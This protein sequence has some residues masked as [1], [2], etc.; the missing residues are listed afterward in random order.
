MSFFASDVMAV[1]I[2]NYSIKGVVLGAK[3]E[4]KKYASVPTPVGAIEGGI[5][6]EP[7]RVAGAVQAL[8]QTLGVK[9]PAVITAIPGQNVFVRLF[10]L[11]GLN[12]KELA[13]AVRYQA[14]GQIPIPPNELVVDWAVVQEIKATKQIEILVVATRK[15]VVQQFTFLFRQAGLQPRIFDLEALALSRIFFTKNH[16]VKP[17]ELELLASIGAAATNICVFEGDVPRFT[18][19]IP[20]GGQRF[21]R[22]LAMERS[23][24]L[25]EAEEFKLSGEMPAESASLL[26]DLAGE[27][28]RSIDFFLSQNKEQNIGR[29]ILSGGGAHLT[30]MPELLSERLQLPVELGRLSDSVKIPKNLIQA[31]NMAEF[32]TTY[33]TALGLA[34]RG[35]KL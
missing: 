28:R 10:T 17:G 13:Q 21:T 24:S 23:I 7:E 6:N 1:D 5:I 29:I 4:L 22:A 33:A 16:K 12:K 11:P 26:E 30:N 20:F 3:K 2:G 27:L 31:A 34:V 8:W 15:S 9:D 25:E 32:Q 18:R 19:S 35:L 14:E